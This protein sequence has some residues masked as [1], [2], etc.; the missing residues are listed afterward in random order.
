MDKINFSTKHLAINKANVQMVATIGAAAFITVFCLFASNTVFNQYKYQGRVIAAVKVADNQLQADF[1]A[2]NG[3]TQAYTKFDAAN[4]NILGSPVTGTANDN[5][6]IVLDALPGAYD[7]PALATSL[8]YILNAN[9]IQN[10]G[11]SGTDD[12]L[13]QTATGPSTNP[14]PVPMPFGLSMSDASYGAT[15][16]LLQYLQQSIRPMSI[17]SLNLSGAQGSLTMSIE[18]HTYFQPAKTLNI[19]KEVVK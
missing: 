5:T 1:T 9:G 6:Q 12:Q 18:A 7:F 16:S 10:G 2:Y 15:Q 14:Q 19:T 11:I 13:N 4:P 3:L 17:D 8:Q